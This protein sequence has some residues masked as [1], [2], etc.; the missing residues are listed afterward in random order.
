MFFPASETHKQ[1]SAAPIK[2][3]RYFSMHG[4]IEVSRINNFKTITYLRFIQEM[5]RDLLRVGFAALC[6]E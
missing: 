3:G 2:T 1:K 6:K 4:R 5:L